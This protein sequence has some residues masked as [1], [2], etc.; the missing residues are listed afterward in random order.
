MIRILSLT[1]AGVFL[2]LMVTA[3]NADLFNYDAS[4]INQELMQLQSLENYIAAN[5]D[6]SFTE[7]QSEKNSLVTD[8][9]LNTNFNG[10]CSAQ[11]GEPPLGISPFIWGC[12]L[13][14]VGILVV[15]L[16]TEDKAATKKALN[17]CI[18]GSLIGCV[19]YVAYVIILYA[20]YGDFYYYY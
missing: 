13:G 20:I 9:N 8:L 19:S 12:C 11:D 7:L 14:W 4:R 18:V 3:N 16:I 5:P 15:Y 10:S 2:S 17:G 1:I 6:I